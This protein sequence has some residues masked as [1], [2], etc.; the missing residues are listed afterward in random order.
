MHL[1]FYQAWE[2][3]R[4]PANTLTPFLFFFFPFPGKTTSDTIL[5]ISCVSVLGPLVNLWRAGLLF[6]YFPFFSVFALGFGSLCADVILL[7]DVRNRFREVGDLP[8][9]TQLGTK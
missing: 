4:L 7:M 9:I 8:N 3:I 1:K 5:C 2:S 6:L